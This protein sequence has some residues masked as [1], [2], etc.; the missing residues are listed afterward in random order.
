MA[1]AVASPRLEMTTHLTEQIEETKEVYSS[2]THPLDR[3]AYCT[4]LYT[5]CGTGERIPRESRNF[6]F[7]P[8]I[9]VE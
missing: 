4:V 2:A 7:L 5:S 9:F 8:N 6:G 1:L 3:Y